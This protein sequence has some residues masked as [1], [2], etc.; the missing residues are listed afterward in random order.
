MNKAT[1]LLIGLFAFS[2]FAHAQSSREQANWMLNCQGCHGAEGKVS[3]IGTPV[4]YG[5][6]A[7]FLNTPGGREYLISVPGVVNAP[8][9][10]KDKA[11]L[12]NWIVRTLDPEHLPDDFKPYTAEDIVWGQK[13]PLHTRAAQR[14]VE[15]LEAMGLENDLH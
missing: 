3:A 6:V 7:R 5:K 14:R 10:D 12:M 1:C 8:V 2:S 4:L 9:K 11:E 15:L 13:N